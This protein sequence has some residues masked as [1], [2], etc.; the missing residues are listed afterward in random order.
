MY[1]RLCG[2]RT[3]LGASFVVEGLEGIVE[4]EHV[5]GA[6]DMLVVAM[7][8]MISGTLGRGAQLMREVES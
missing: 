5:K 4:R 3:H 6:H 1:C 8:N 7:M 2:A